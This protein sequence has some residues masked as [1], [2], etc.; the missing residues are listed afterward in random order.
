MSVFVSYLFC[1]GDF[2]QTKHEY[3]TLFASA[4]A[5]AVSGIKGVPHA[6]SSAIKNPK[7]GDA[8]STV[9]ETSTVGRFTSSVAPCAASPCDNDSDDS[10]YECCS[11]SSDCSVPSL[12]PCIFLS[13]S[14]ESSSEESSV[15]CATVE[16]V[17]G[18]R[19]LRRRH[20]RSHRRS[21]SRSQSSLSQ[22]SRRRHVAKHPNSSS[23]DEDS[24]DSVPMLL[25]PL[26]FSSDESLF[27]EGSTAKLAEDSRR[28]RLC[29]RRSRSRSRSRSSRSQSSRRRRVSTQP[30]SLSADV[31][32]ATAPKLP[33]DRQFFGESACVL[34][35][36]KLGKPPIPVDR[37]D[38]IDSLGFV[39]EE[40]RPSHQDDWHRLDALGPL[41]HERWRHIQCVHFAFPQLQRGQSCTLRDAKLP[42]YQAQHVDFWQ[43]VLQHNE[44]TGHIPFQV[45]CP[46]RNHSNNFLTIDNS[47]VVDQLSLRWNSLGNF[48]MS[49]PEK[50]DLKR[51]S[52]YRDFG[53]TSGKCTSRKDSIMGVA[54]PR[55]K[56]GTTD[57]TIVDT[58]VTMSEHVKSTKCEWFGPSE[59]AFGNRRDAPQLKFPRQIHPENIIP[60]L[61]IAVNDV[62]APCQCHSD[63]HNPDTLE[64]SIVTSVSKGCVNRGKR[65][66]AVVVVYGRKSIDDL[67]DRAER[68]GPYVDYLCEQYNAFPEERKVLDHRYLRSGVPVNCV[69]GLNVLK[70]PCNLDPW[71]HYG[72]VTEYA[73]R[74]QVKYNLSYPELVSVGRALGV[75]PNTSHH[76]VAAACCLLQQDTLDR[77]HRVDYRFGYLLANIM[78]E[79]DAKIRR[80]RSPLP[81]RR[82][83]HYSRFIL[84][85]YVEWIDQCESMLCTCL[86][87]LSEQ[88]VGRSKT[89]RQA[90][91][92][93]VRSG[94][95]SAIPQVDHLG[96]NH[97]VGCF[98]TWG[99]LPL[100][101]AGKI[102]L[103]KTRPV[104]WLLDKFFTK[105]EQKKIK[106]EDVFANVSAAIEARTGSK[107]SK[108]KTENTNCKVCRLNRPNGD[109][110][111]RFQETYVP[112]QATY[113]YN[114]SA[115]I[116][117]L[118]SGEEH[119][120]R[121][122]LIDRFPYHGVYVSR[123][124]LWSEIGPVGR[125]LTGTSLSQTFRK[126][127][128]DANR[129]SM[130]TYVPFELTR[131]PT[132]NRWLGSVFRACD[133]RLK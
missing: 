7:D 38:G 17:K 89:A 48:A 90:A 45:Y 120:L 40:P 85:T 4:Y 82:Y 73:L 69:A 15:E 24:D 125:P 64:N 71:G 30:N 19:R 56:P 67:S 1:I 94:I 100:W 32:P 84:P 35:W 49:S 33:E 77:R 31:Q 58:F 18:C 25:S 28:R 128:F 109:T 47:G 123:E 97:F 42:H 63:R 50:P 112:G 116:V 127:I 22:S 36:G 96:S 129:H 117:T 76:F 101:C 126:G 34:G 20:R 78:M 115:I 113:T 70:V 74:L 132:G 107:C 62:D 37:Y 57:A 130:C 2:S 16:L 98:A 103:T 121:R 106:L 39:C 80:E 53:F 86:S 61:R 12:G 59:S 105:A 79:I 54:M 87:A 99:I 91:Y 60:A 13:S 93:Q 104:Q 46:E 75:T 44:G 81:P 131:T 23:S 11:D 95:A 8:V 83:N 52:F 3:A 6:S 66:R 124:R 88:E 108:R 27:E 110:D 29:R 102:E 5:A 119:V 26:S 133:Y 41:S 111:A 55:M 14:D 68:H 10:S 21:Q 114:G 118:A 65:K 43:A 122:P 51:Q 92:K 9:T 72:S